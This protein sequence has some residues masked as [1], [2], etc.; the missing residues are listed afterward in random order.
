MYAQLQAA[1]NA[2]EASGWAWLVWETIARQLLVLQMENQ[3]KL[4]MAGVVTILG[5]EGW[6]HAYYL[7]YQNRRSDYVD[8]FMTVINWAWAAK[9]FESLQP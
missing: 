3:Q 4:L 6:E 8:A 5:I 1:A 2:G 9:R 7:K